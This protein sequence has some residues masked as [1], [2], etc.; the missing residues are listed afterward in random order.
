MKFFYAALVLNPLAALALIADDSRAALSLLG[1]S[2]WC[3]LYALWPMMEDHYIKRSNHR[4]D[5]QTRFRDGV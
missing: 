5:L 2:V 4:A 1:L 3:G